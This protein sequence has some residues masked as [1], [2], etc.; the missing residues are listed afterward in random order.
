MYIELVLRDEKTDGHKD[1]DR[2]IV[3]TNATQADFDEVADAIV[4]NLDLDSATLSNICMS[5]YD[6]AL[7]KAKTDAYE[8]AGVHIIDIDRWQE[9]KSTVPAFV[10]FA[11]SFYCCQE[12]GKKTFLRECR[13]AGNIAEVHDVPAFLASIAAEANAK[14]AAAYHGL[15]GD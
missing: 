9:F 2:T 14:A 1:I 6:R 3:Q 7:A 12:I 4:N 11:D 15:T 8:A 13:A 5:A 10:S